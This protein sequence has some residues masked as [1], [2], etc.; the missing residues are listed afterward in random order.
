MP[1]GAVAPFVSFWRSRSMAAWRF[2]SSGGTANAVPD[3]NG[4]DGKA[5]THRGSRR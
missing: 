4:G 1:L 5:C 2:A 3:G